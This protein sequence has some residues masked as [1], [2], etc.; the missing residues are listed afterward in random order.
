MTQFFGSIGACLVVG[1][2]E[3]AVLA[4]I[5][6]DAARPRRRPRDEFLGRLPTKV[7]QMLNVVTTV[8][9]KTRMNW[10]KCRVRLVVSLSNRSKDAVRVEA[11]AL[12][13]S[14]SKGAV[15]DKSTGN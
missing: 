2:N 3:N 10:F 11:R 5:A 15:Q 1:T 7:L 4:E 13:V 9:G 14:T 12:V 8:C 6:G